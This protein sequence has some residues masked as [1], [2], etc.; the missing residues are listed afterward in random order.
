MGM[1]LG[2]PTLI[3]K[4][5]TKGTLQ[6]NYFA[7]TFPSLALPWGEAC[8]TLRGDTERRLRRD[9]FGK[10]SRKP[11]WLQCVLFPS[12]SSINTKAII[13]TYG[14]LARTYVQR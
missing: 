9:E 11:Y 10:K 1:P 2:K 3:H 5:Q 8:P 4:D 7:S 14:L 6:R 13:Y 12:I